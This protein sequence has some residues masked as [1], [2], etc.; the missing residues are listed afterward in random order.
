MSCG[1][2]SKH[3]L[4][5]FKEAI[6]AKEESAISDLFS[7]RKSNYDD[8]VMECLQFGICEIHPRPLKDIPYFHF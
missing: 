1:N 8:E 4:Q 3:L 6:F 7:T 2:T 5:D